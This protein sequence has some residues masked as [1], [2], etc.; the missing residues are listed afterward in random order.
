M[1][2]R[3][4]TLAAM[5]AVGSL[6]ANVQA[7]DSTEVSSPSEQTSQI[8]NINTASAEELSK[9]NGIGDAKSQAIIAYRQQHGQFESVEQITQV[10]GIGE[11]IL[12]KNKA[13][14]TV[15]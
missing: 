3:S 15:K 14:I 13:L 8:V 9:L 5:I 12:T 4:L 10:D 1:T 7:A 6:A 2:F 11:S